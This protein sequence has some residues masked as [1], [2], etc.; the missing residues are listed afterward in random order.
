MVKNFTAPC[1]ALLLILT[2]CATASQSEMKRFVD[3]KDE[4]VRSGSS[5]YPYLKSKAVSIDYSQEVQPGV[6]EYAFIETFKWHVDPDKRCKFIFVVEKDTG[7]ITAWK[8][9]NKPEYCLEN[10]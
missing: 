2:A 8:Y 4:V 3:V 10:R 7:T 9:N 6:V 1:I 5:I